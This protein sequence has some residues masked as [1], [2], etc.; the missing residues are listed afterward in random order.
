G[1]ARAARYW[2]LPGNHRTAVAVIGEL[3]VRRSVLADHGE[4]CH[5]RAVAHA[6]HATAEV[7]LAAR[8]VV[9]VGECGATEHYV[10]EGD[11]HAADEIHHER[12]AERG[13]IVKLQQ[14]ASQME[15]D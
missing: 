2:L 5:M 6:E 10:D 12:A 7:V 14:P 8:A 11:R 1:Q 4:L 3:E 9:R 13:R 15:G